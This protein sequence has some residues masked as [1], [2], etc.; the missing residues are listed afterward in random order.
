[1]SL[2]PCVAEIRPPPTQK[3]VSWELQS[4]PHRPLVTATPAGY[5][6]LTQP[7]NCPMR[8]SR[9]LR[10][11]K[12]WQQSRRGACVYTGLSELH[13][14][15]T[16]MLQCP[17][18]L[19]WASVLLYDSERRACNSWPPPFILITSY[20]SRAAHSHSGSSHIP[21]QLSTLPQKPHLTLQL[22]TKAPSKSLCHSVKE[23]STQRRALTH[24]LAPITIFP[25]ISTS[26]S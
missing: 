7:P 1:M 13:G 11:S 12:L 17:V 5:S 4:C 6:G 19:K 23:T 2:Q 20:Q 16:G 25:W 3:P 14:T 22:R 10:L 9:V 26:G 18:D 21:A 24:K 15:T 8:R